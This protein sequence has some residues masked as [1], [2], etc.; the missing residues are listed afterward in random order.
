MNK[1]RTKY[2]TIPCITMT[3][4]GIRP[5]MSAQVPCKSKGQHPFS[6]LV[7][8]GCGAGSNS[9]LGWASSLL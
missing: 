3:W 8:I 6:V 7:F 5:E 9:G 4:Y 1:P 2:A